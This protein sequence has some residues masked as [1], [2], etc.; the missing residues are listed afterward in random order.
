MPPERSYRYVLD[1]NLGAWPMVECIKSLMCSSAH[2]IGTSVTFVMFCQLMTAVVAQNGPAVSTRPLTAVGYCR[3]C[4][5]P[6]E[7]TAVGCCG[8]LGWLGGSHG[9]CFQDVTDV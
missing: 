7:L 6:P 1:F 5:P 9:C 4:W 8:L 3:P 2:P